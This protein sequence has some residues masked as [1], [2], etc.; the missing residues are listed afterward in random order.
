L[1]IELALEDHRLPLAQDIP[2]KLFEKYQE[3]IQQRTELARY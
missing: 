3:I 1:T 2:V